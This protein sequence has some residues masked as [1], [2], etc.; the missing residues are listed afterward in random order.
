MSVK[1]VVAA[2]SG[3]VDSCAAAS[4]LQ[5]AGYDVVG[6]TMKLHDCSAAKESP[7][8]CGIDGIARARNAAMK[9]GIRHY[10]LDCVDEFQ[11]K[12]LKPAWSD[13]AD[14]RTPSP[15][16]LC[17]E[18]I[19]FGL[20]FDF[21]DNMGAEYIATGHYG[22]IETG[23]DGTLC[24]MRGKDR[25]K[26][27]SYFLAGLTQSQLKR[28]LFPLGDMTKPETREYVRSNGLPG[29]ETKESQDA[30]LVGEYDSFAE[31]LM[32][33]FN[34]TLPAGD[35]Y[36]ED[37]KV[38]ARHNGIHRYTIGQRKG[39]GL[40]TYKTYWVKD[41]QADNNA[42]VVTDDSSHLM[43]REFTAAGLDVAGHLKSVGD[44]ECDVQ[45][46]YRQ[47]PQKARVTIGQDGLAHVRF[48]EPV[49]A[50]TPGQ[51]AVFYD[52]DRVLGRG[53]IAISSTSY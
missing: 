10:V 17:N 38:M 23:A 18:R 7:S 4:L 5:Q 31:M 32:N 47:T 43:S 3:G 42:V 21:A 37:G 39:L 25:K 36:D 40:N 35:I 29:A 19:K 52:G 46:R 15:C 51:A 41:I 20:L 26:D 8:C 27:Q 13:Y 14:G 24:L 50:V 45:V 48:A 16:L 6:V 1:R 28:T 11:E 9:M 33:R 44:I 22:R 12:V 34:S 2:M 30:C 53:W 49:S